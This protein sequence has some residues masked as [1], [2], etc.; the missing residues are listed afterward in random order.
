MKALVCPGDGTATVEMREVEEPEPGSNELVIDVA[1]MAVNRGE[2]RL[3]AA[4]DEGW[5]PG[6]DVA[7]VVSAPAAD[8]SGPPKGSRVVAWVDQAGWAERAVAE[9]DRVAVLA[10]GTTFAEAST[11]PVAGI[12]ALRT[13]RVGGD[14]AAKRVLITGAAGGVGRFAVEMAARSGARVSA[15]TGG[16]NRS[17]GL[18]ELGATEI[19]HSIDEADGWFDLILESAGGS[20]LER[21]FQLVA[22][23]GTVVVFGSSS[24]EPSRFAFGDFSQRPSR[25]EV[26]FVYESGRPFGPDLQRLAD[27][28]GDGMLHPTVGM[29]VGWAEAGTALRALADRQVNGKAVLTID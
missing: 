12:T 24:G 5:R 3:L 13:L 28:V 8:G 6:Q 15:V 26:F 17:D 22:H 11:L 10:D 20:S 1:A 25:I 18:E 19:V 21:A 7:G 14:L 2:L 23:S 9:T 4:R 16:P 27:L 29:E